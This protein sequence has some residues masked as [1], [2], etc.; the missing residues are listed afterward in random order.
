MNK[1]RVV[2]LFSGCGG[3]D[4][5]LLGGF[6]FLGKHYKRLS[7]SVVFAND[8]DKYAVETYKKNFPHPISDEDIRKIKST[9][10]PE[11][12]ILVGGF[13]CQTFSIVGQR[14]GISDLRGQLFLEMARILK[15]RQPSVFIGENVKG[16]VNLQKGKVLDLI[17]EKFQESGYDVTFKVLN[18]VNY[19]VPQK[20]ERVFI[21]GFRNDLQ[22]SFEFPKSTGG[23]VPLK[24]VLQQEF[25]KRYIFSKR[26]VEG[27]KKSNKAFNK[28][29]VQDPE[30]P[31][32]TINSHLAK[33]SLNG[34][35]PVLLIDG[36][37]DSY[38]RFTPLEAS[39]IQSFPDTFDFPVSEFQTYKQIGN[40]IPPVMMWHLTNSV[41]KALE[42][43]KCKPRTKIKD[44]QK[45]VDL[46]L[47]A[48]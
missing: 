14:K 25:D 47:F 18:S 31:C 21:V 15:D 33:V 12:D 42:N 7:T 44:N 38:R 5:G 45:Y 22:T 4:L 20:R 6:W 16:L 9:D 35:D 40:A 23:F 32:N 13:P 2:S 36:K 3:A 46:P 19:G 26:A 43:S 27:L 37:K 29:R 17:I 11:H 10:I 1:L 8:V 28:G 24:S 34:T 41:I 30:L 39:R 48:Y